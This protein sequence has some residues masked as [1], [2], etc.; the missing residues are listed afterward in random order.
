M[1]LLAKIL[2]FVVIGSVLLLYAVGLG[3][4]AVSSST[5]DVS[6]QPTNAEEARQTIEALDLQQEYPF[7]HHFFASPHGRMHY[8]DE[9]E[10]EQ[11][12]ICLHGNP[13][14]SFLY[15]NFVK[16]L[17]GSA[18]VIAPDLI[19]FGLSE[20]NPDWT[21]Y[22]IAGHVEDVSALVEALDLRNITLVFQDWGGP[23]GLGV[24]LEHPER[25]RALVVMN[26]IGFV[27]PGLTDDG[28]PLPLRILRV[29]LLGEQLVQGLGMFNRAGIAAGIARPER[30]TDQV[31]RAYDA[32]AGNWQ[33]RAGALSFPRLIPTDPDDPAIALLE[34]E[35][36]WLETFR[37]EVLIFWGMKD[38]AFGPAMLGE[39]RRR[40]PQAPVLELPNAGH[41]LQE[42]AH[43]EI[44]PRIREALG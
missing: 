24:A 12:V 19:G 32:V 14:W 43:E 13:T 6:T 2:G 8:V 9:G 15:R 41:F 7:D 29:P 40:F 23:I 38:F 31:L 1:K 20:K 18:R 34:R 26:T 44:V 5:P 30:R 21:S 4:Y 33:E 22:S 11:T 42:D 37:G 36:K 28:P 35:G 3:V 16:G 25:V 10:G 17:S 39:W 27:M